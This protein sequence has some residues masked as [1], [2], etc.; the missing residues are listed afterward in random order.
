[1]RG[2]AHNRRAQRSRL[3]RISMFNRMQNTNAVNTRNKLEPVVH[4]HDEN[5]GGK[6][7]K[8]FARPASRIG[9]SQVVKHFHQRFH[10]TGHAAN[11]AAARS[12][13]SFCR[14]AERKSQHQQDHI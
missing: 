4:K 5:D 6:P 11:R 10:R 9:L 13:R 8:Y 2:S 7:R 3:H 1:M 14:A 12:Q